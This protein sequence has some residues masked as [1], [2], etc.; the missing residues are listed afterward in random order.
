MTQ[1][2]VCRRGGMSEARS[3]LMKRLCYM[4]SLNF[5]LIGKLVLLT[6]PTIT[7]RTQQIES[8]SRNDK[9]ASVLSKCHYDRPV[10][11]VPNDSKPIA[12]QAFTIFV[13]I[14]HNPTHSTRYNFFSFQMKKYKKINFYLQTFELMAVGLH[15]YGD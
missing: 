14:K 11:T 9:P 8:N 10:S 12:I 7:K 1:M 4:R 5:S 13:Y 6:E 3:Y 15:R 2:R